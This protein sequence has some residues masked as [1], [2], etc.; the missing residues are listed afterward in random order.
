MLLKNNLTIIAIVT[1]YVKKNHDK[2]NQNVCGVF[3]N[4]A[5]KTYSALTSPFESIYFTLLHADRNKLPHASTRYK[6]IFLQE[7]QTNSNMISAIF[8]SSPNHT[9]YVSK[10]LKTFP[11]RNCHGCFQLFLILTVFTVTSCFLLFV[12][13]LTFL[14]SW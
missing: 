1:G 12:F 10:I 3:C 13:F 2:Y 4:V 14:F 9:T 5:K 11:Y 6:G 8:H 7:S